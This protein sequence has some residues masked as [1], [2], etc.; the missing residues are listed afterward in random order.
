MGKKSK[1]GAGAS[2]GNVILV[3]GGSGFV[4]QKLVGGL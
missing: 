1:K 4:G 3:T 2:N